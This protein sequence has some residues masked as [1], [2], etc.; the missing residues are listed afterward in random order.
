MPWASSNYPNNK[1]GEFE[2]VR[3]V[4]DIQGG[5]GADA[6]FRLAGARATCRPLHSERAGSDQSH[7]RDQ[8]LAL[9]RCVCSNH[10]AAGARQGLCEV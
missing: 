8:S 4:H 7:G 9:W 5:N 1:L 6:S 3:E 2:M 10:V